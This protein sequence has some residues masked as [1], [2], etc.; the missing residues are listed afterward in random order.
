MMGFATF[1][2][3]VMEKA[4]AVFQNK[5]GK[6]EMKLS[7]THKNNKEI[8]S[9]L[10]RFEN[11][12]NMVPSIN[13]EKL[14]EAYKE[15]GD[16][17]KT[18]E[19]VIERIVEDHGNQVQYIDKIN[20]LKGKVIP[21]LINTYANREWLESI[22]H[23]PFFDLSV[24]Y[25]FV[26]DTNPEQDIISAIINND[27]ADLLGCNEEQLYERAFADVKDILPPKLFDLNALAQNTGY[28][29]PMEDGDEVPPFYVI[30]NQKMTYGAPLVLLPEVQE[31]LAK[32]FAPYGGDYFL[33]PS[34]VHE[35]MAV[36]VT[37][38]PG[39]LLELIRQ[40]NFGE[41]AVED[42]LSNSAYRWD[43]VHKMFS[44]ITNLST[45]TEE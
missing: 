38:A 9:L 36:P 42:R 29:I 26:F 30:T 12:S 23:R 27:F 16:V 3:E 15:I 34:S 22:P 21:Q 20:S 1:V 25:R 7:K 4:P 35:M 31:E 18:L 43:S 2:E 8:S 41:V 33:I 19:N 24:V 6:V 13:L 5:C 39:D 28:P 44:I 32:V 45:I 37:D 17:E 40:I 11:D 14:Y 10:V